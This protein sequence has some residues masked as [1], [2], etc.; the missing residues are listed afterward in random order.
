MSS[1]E[2]VRSR[3]DRHPACFGIF[4]PTM[5]RISLLGALVLAIAAMVPSTVAATLFPMTVAPDGKVTYSGTQRS[6]WLKAGLSGWAMGEVTGTVQATTVADRFGGTWLKEGELTS[7]GSNDLFTVELTSG[8]WGIGPT[9]GTWAIDSSFWS[10]YGRAVISM[11]VGNGAGNPDWYLWE[12]KT[13]ETAGT[14]FYH[15]HAGNG[16]GMSNLFLWGSGTPQR[17]PDAGSTLVL[18][19]GLL[20]VLAFT[21]VFRR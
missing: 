13:N 2:E 3:F 16:G 20:S 8:T 5:K 12:V 10:T 15:R 6:A 21:R 4:P 19:G 17:T 9:Y 1:Y 18:V 7:P 11:H 14:F